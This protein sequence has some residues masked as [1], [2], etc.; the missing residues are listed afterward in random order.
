MPTIAEMSNVRPAWCMRV[1]IQVVQAPNAPPFY[2]K[3]NRLDCWL[4]E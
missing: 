3:N 1:H 4:C 2:L